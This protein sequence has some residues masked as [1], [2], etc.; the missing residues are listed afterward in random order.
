[1]Y[2]R[3]NFRSEIPVVDSTA[4][5]I[6]RAAGLKALRALLAIDVDEVSS[7]FGVVFI[8]GGEELDLN[9]LAIAIVG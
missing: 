6:T 1:V 7:S 9:W 5:K 4:G 3:Q 2:T 8:V